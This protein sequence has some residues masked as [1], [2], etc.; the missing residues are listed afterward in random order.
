MTTVKLLATIGYRT[1]MHSMVHTIPL[2]TPT[3]LLPDLTHTTICRTTTI[4]LAYKLTPAPVPARTTHH[5][6]TP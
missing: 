5:H 4:P 1:I 3:Q 6:T 2:A